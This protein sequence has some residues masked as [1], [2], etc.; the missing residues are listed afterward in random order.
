[1]NIRNEDVRSITVEIPEGHHHLRS[2]LLLNDGTELTLQEA[3]VANL[4]RA[5][6]GVKTHPTRRRMALSGREVAEGLKH[7]F[8]QWQLLEPEEGGGLHANTKAV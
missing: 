5:F 6:L 8:A 2:T 3:T 4:V 7:G 1:M